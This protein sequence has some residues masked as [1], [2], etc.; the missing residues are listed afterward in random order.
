MESEEE[1]MWGRV[2]KELG[3][4]MG[5]KEGGGNCGNIENKILK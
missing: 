4:E 1:W 3:E 5:A 2:R